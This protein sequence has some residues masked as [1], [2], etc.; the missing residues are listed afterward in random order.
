MGRA[1]MVACGSEYTLVLTAVGLVYSCG[2]GGNGQLGLGDLE[3][4]LMLTLVGAEQF[5][6]AQIVMVA[7]GASH[8]VAM[9]A[10][11]RVWT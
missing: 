10:E 5:N 4:Q 1:V 9:G 3:H 8:S 2:D 6:G 11:G 7:A